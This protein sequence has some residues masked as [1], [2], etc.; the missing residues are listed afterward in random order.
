MF[1]IDNVKSKFSFKNFFRNKRYLREDYI[2][3]PSRFR[4]FG[5]V[6]FCG[7]LG[8]GK[9]L[10]ATRLIENYVKMYPDIK[11]CSNVKLN[12]VPADRLIRFTGLDEFTA[13]DNKDKGI[14]LYLDE[15]VNQF[16]SSL[17]KDI[18]DDWIIFLNLIRKKGCLLIGTGPKFSR[19]A[20]PFRERFDYVCVCNGIF[21][22]CDG[23]LI[24]SNYWYRCNLA[25]KI[26][27]DGETETT[28][29]MDMVKHQIFT[30]SIEDYQRYDSFELVE[31]INSSDRKKVKRW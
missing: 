30:I 1:Q 7:E 23:H 8:S 29:N 4:E 16:P 3:N 21:E 25:D 27:G 2:N 26:L 22:Y 19:L 6:I 18:S 20:K 28:H 11:V 24:Q 10:S 17:S 14:I 13:I 15:I 31:V 9:S 5:V 12:C